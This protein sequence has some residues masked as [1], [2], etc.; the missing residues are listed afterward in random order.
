[1]QEV[2]SEQTNTSPTKKVETDFLLLLLKQ[3]VLQVKYT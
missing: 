2:V 3:I 1:M